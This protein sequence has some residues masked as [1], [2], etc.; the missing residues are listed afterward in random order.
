VG[1]VVWIHIWVLC[2][3]PLVFVTVLCQYHAVFISMTLWYSLKSDIVIPPTLLFFAQYC[4]GY[5]QSMCFQMNFQI[6]FSISVINV[7]GI[8][9]G[10]ALNM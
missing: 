6:D 3:V 8:L 7:T 5:L 4:L 1:I 10:I 9:M 2:S